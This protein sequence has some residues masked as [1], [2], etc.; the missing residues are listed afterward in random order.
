MNMVK[1]SDYVV[2]ALEAHG[3]RDVFLLSGG[4]MM[5]L[6]DSVARSG[7]HY[8]CNL[9]EQASAI[10]ADA[11]AQ[12]ID[13]LGVCMVTTGPGATNAI[14]GC[15]SSWI[16]SR[17]VLFISGQ[18]KRSD[19]TGDSGVRQIGTQEINIT[20]IVESITKYAVTVMEPSEVRYHIDKAIYIALHGNKGP[21]WIDIP[22]DIQGMQFDEGLF[23]DFDPVREGIEHLPELDKAC[24]KGIADMLRASERPALLVGGRADTKKSKEM[25]REFSHRLGIPVL[26]TA[27]SKMVFSDTDALF[28]GYP[29]SYGPRYSG[30]IIQNADCAVIMGTTVTNLMAAYDLSHFAYKAEKAYVD[31][32][33]Y[34]VKYH[35]QKMNVKYSLISDIEV[36]I[37]ALDKEMSEDSTLGI[38]PWLDYCREA[39]DAFPI[40]KDAET[41]SNVNP[42]LL[43]HNL[44]E[45]T[46]DNDVIVSSG[47]GSCDAMLPFVFRR[48]E[49]QVFVG[50][51]KFGSMGFAAPLAIGA[52]IACGRRRTITVEGDGGL[53]HNI[54]ELALIEQYSLPIKLF[55]I[56]NG[57]YASIKEMQARHFNGRYAGCDK[58]SGVNLCRLQT[59]AEL[60]GL[61]YFE[62]SENEA[63]D[64]VLSEIM[65]DDNPVLCEVVVHPDFDPGPKSVSKAHMDGTMTSS[66]L[67]DLYPFLTHEE[68]K[69]WNRFLSHK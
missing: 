46:R 19:L 28:F 36:F 64:S 43:A 55:V 27:Y 1:I 59:L 24:I 16:D 30:L 57:G 18:V 10:C 7:I 9:H 22:L 54:Q 69:Y 35:R 56:S 61:K 38:Q 13:G 5:H 40:Y 11:Y 58:D 66:A 62:L 34:E 53:H 15:A 39:R 4:G 8:Y 45:Y 50:F 2:N 65:R 23:L 33:P 12:A 44:S 60:Y 63:I 68:F 3:V 6:L 25:I 20:K 29:S 21:V 37:G 31:V 67:E 49:G 26:A 32:D 14:T 51:P 48:K 47:A 41:P 52:C 42:Y 17:P